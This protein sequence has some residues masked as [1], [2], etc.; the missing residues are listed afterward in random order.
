MKILKTK[1][2]IIGAGGY[3][4]GELIRLLV[5]HPWVEIT[6]AQSKSCAGRK[7]SEVH[8]DL[9]GETELVFAFTFNEVVDILFLC[10]AHGDA[11]KF[12]QTTQIDPQTKII[13]LSEDFRLS[14]NNTIKERTFV[15]GLPELN[16]DQI[17]QSQN[18][19]NH[20]RFAT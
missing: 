3:A 11:E 20:G 17:S 13:D 6:F 9:L 12:M 18:F 16:R 2:G 7:L 14:T 1:V 4:G 10:G 8:A 19:S 5:N 15:Y